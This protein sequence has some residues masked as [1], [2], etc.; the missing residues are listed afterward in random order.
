[1]AREKLE[2]AE[3]RQSALGTERDAALCELAAINAEQAARLDEQ[4][5]A[6]CELAALAA[7]NETQS[8]A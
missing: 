2:Q 5:A 8:G 1:M 6:L 7:A 3:K 4:D